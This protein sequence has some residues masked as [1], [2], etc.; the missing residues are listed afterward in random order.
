MFKTA[1]HK[2]YLLVLRTASRRSLRW[3]LSEQHWLDLAV[4]DCYYCGS[5]PGNMIKSYGFKYNGLDR[6]DSSIGYTLTNV[7]TCCRI[8]NMA[9]SD[10]SQ[11]EFYNW[12]EK[13]YVKTLSK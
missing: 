5:M 1:E 6:I 7:V 12:I 2:T 13:V 9:K 4:Q 11:Q 3:E 8:C 10:M